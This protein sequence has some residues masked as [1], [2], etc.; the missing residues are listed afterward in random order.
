[1]AKQSYL[2]W[3]LIRTDVGGGSQKTKTDHKL[4]YLTDR[5][6]KPSCTKWNWNHLNVNQLVL[7]MLHNPLTKVVM[8]VLQLVPTVLT[9]YVFNCFTVFLSKMIHIL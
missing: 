9:F 1:M 7:D 5:C 6:V 2:L 3:R 4:P 8:S